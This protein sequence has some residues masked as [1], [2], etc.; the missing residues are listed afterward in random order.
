MKCYSELKRRKKV[1]RRDD[2]FVRCRGTIV[3]KEASVVLFVGSEQ[4]LT[5]EY[6]RRSRIGTF[7]H[8]SCGTTKLT[9][10]RHSLLSQDFTFPLFT[11]TINSF[12]FHYTKLKIIILTAF[13]TTQ[14]LKI[15]ISP[16][17]V[18]KNIIYLQFIEIAI[19]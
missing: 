13:N 16:Y 6:A 9:P 5:R 18:T 4:T 17:N 3:R 8:D 1:S 12:S 15:K 10:H 7:Q 11:L 2:V 19:E 14:N